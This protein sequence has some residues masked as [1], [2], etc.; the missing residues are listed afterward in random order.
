MRLAD[1]IKTKTSNASERQSAFNRINRKHVDFVITRAS[2][3]SIIGVIELDDKSHD[4][5]ER[6]DRDAFVDKALGAAEIPVVHVE[7]K[8]SYSL[9]DVKKALISFPDMTRSVSNSAA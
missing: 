1:V 2:D 3:A 6:Q 4:K 9:L 5:P 7:A 8:A